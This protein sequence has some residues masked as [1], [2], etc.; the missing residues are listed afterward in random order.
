VIN[1][2]LEHGLPVVATGAVGAVDDLVVDDVNGYVTRTGDV[3]ELRDAM[4]RI[5]DWDDT[6]W[7]SAATTCVETAR[8]WSI[9]AAATA[10]VDACRTSVERDAR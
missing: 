8:R 3:A 5:A 10:F 4:A 9:D 1:E 7:R 6:Q 2:A